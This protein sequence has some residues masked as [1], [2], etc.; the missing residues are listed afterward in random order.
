M[1]HIY[2]INGRRVVLD[3]THGIAYPI[4]SLAQKITEAVAPPLTAECPTS[5]R[6]AFAKYDSRDLSAAYTEVYELY[7]RGILSFQEEPTV[8]PPTK[9][10][11]EITASAEDVLDELSDALKNGA[12]HLLVT[13]FHATAALTASIL[14]MVGN[15]AELHLLVQIPLETL[16]P[17]DLRFLTENNVYLYID[18][19]FPPDLQP[20]LEKGIRRFSSELPTDGNRKTLE[21]FVRLLE[22]KRQAGQPL[23]FAPFAFSLCPKN[24]DCANAAACAECCARQFCRGSRLDE[25]GNRTSA[26]TREQL[27]LECAAVFFMDSAEH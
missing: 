13:V 21:R 22:E 17:D 23:D 16:S 27:L 2:K 7:R 26:C 11:T 15:S 18:G 12:T 9:L 8:A 24:T 25:V 1:N 19:A 20:I 6:Y 3:C 5:L 4:S 14:E 10:Y